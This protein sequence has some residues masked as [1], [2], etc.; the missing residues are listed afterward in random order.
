MD[1]H[2]QITLYFKD[3]SEG[4]TVAYVTAE[5][6]RKS[7]RNGDRFAEP[8]DE[9]TLEISCIPAFD[10]NDLESKDW[11]MA[12]IYDTAAELAAEYAAGPEELEYD[13]S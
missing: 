9:P 5:R 1:F 11:Q 4:S 7:Q 8:D 6:G 3:G 2:F 10:P 13:F 12:Q